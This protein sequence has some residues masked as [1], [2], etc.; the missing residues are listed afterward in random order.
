MAKP[1]PFSPSCRVPRTN[2]YPGATNDRVRRLSVS[3]NTWSFRKFVVAPTPLVMQPAPRPPPR[4]PG[5]R[6]S[7]VDPNITANDSDLS[8]PVQAEPSNPGCARRNF[9]YTN[10]SPSRPSS[11]LSASSTTECRRLSLFQTAVPHISYPHSKSRKFLTPA[12]GKTRRTVFLFSQR[13][14]RRHTEAIRSVPPS[15]CHFGTR[16]RLSSEVRTDAR[17][18]RSP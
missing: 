10:A 6:P 12:A 2:R 5:L 9:S 1:T 8:I 11:S 13:S 15:P 3:A 7:D 4:R 16:S 18:L 14:A 17:T